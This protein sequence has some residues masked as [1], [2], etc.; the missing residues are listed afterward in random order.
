MNDLPDNIRAEQAKRVELRLMGF[1]VVSL[2]KMML[3]K[4]DEKKEAGDK[5]KLLK[6]HD[7]DAKEAVAEIIDMVSQT[8]YFPNLRVIGVAGDGQLKHFS[9]NDL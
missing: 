1:Y 9:D 4:S 2:L 3:L 6:E 5:P 8:Q 7:Q